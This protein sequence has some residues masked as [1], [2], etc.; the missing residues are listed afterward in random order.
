[1]AAGTYYWN[2]GIFLW[3]AS[4]ILDALETN[5]PQMR[6][7]IAAIADAM[8]TDAFDETLEREFAAIEG[9][10]IDYAVMENYENVVMIEAPFPWDD[11]GSWQALARLHEADADGNTVVGSHVGIDTRGSIIHSQEGHTIV[12]IGVEDL[13]VVQTA[14]ATLVAPK[15]AEERVREVVKRLEEEKRNDLL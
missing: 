11:V 2:S 7:H 1:M 12:T 14:D 4:T 9:V 6:A 8:E 3:R 10:S 13:I 15:R 5:A